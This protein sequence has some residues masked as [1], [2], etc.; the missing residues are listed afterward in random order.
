MC[1]RVVAFAEF[2]FLVITRPPLIVDCLQ[3]F[4]SVFRF[5]NALGE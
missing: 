4:A 1:I 3:R 5:V 2:A